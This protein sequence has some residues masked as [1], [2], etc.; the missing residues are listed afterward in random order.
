MA[1]KAKK[2]KP[3]P[4]TEA[5]LLGIRKRHYG[6]L[7]RAV[8][9]GAAVNSGDLMGF[10]PFMYACGRMDIESIN[11]MLAF[12]ADPFI[13]DMYGFDAFYYAA[14]NRKHKAEILELL[15][16]WTPAQQAA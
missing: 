16:A 8:R 13:Q 12:G 1:K 6:Q 7:S 2:Q 15:Q 10:T 14:K 5:L 9:R 11:L 3:L 4:A